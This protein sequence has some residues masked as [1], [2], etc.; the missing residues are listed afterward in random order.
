VKEAMALQM[1]KEVASLK[2]NLEVAERKVKDA[3]DDLHAVVEGKFAMSLSVDSKHILGLFLI[4]HPW[5]SSAP[6]RQRTP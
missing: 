4:F 5:M 1:E 2:K 3:P 6:R